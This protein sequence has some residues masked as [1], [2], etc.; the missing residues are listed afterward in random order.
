M[1]KRSEWSDIAERSAAAASGAHHWKKYA[2]RRNLPICAALALLAALG[3]GIW[4]VQDRVREAWAA[5]PVISPA[6]TA[7]PG[8]PMWIWLALGALAL[9]TFAAFRPGR[10][11]DSAPV[12]L[13]KILGLGLAWLIL[14]GLT[15]G[16]AF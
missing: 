7:H 4:W 12:L 16:F 2:F 5:R 3:Y 9:A 13:G 14:I 10:T 1:L 8:V 6:P 15:I 11:T